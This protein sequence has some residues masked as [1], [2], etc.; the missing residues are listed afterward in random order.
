MSEI[1]F[2]ENCGKKKCVQRKWGRLMFNARGCL[3]GFVTQPIEDCPHRDDTRFM[4][5]PKENGEQAESRATAK[6]D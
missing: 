6:E 3:E 1:L 5:P 4:Q 2:C